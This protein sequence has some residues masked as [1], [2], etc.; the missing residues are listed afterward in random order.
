PSRCPR[1]DGRTRPRI[2]LA[3]ETLRAALPR[4]HAELERDYP[5]TAAELASWKPL[6]DDA[7]QRAFADLGLDPVKV[8]RVAALIPAAMRGITSE[9]T[10]GTYGDLDDAIEALIGG[11]V[12]Y[13]EN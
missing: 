5:L 7:C 3:I 10:L 4:D 8:R 12:A 13:L 6:W 2:S 11:I 1:S 9:R